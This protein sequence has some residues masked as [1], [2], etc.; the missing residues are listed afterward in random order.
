MLK[1]NCDNCAL[2]SANG[3]ICPF[4]RADMSGKDGCP[5]HASVEDFCEACGNLIVGPAFIIPKDGEAKRVCGHCATVRDCRI[6]SQHECRFEADHTCPEPLL[7]MVRRQEGNMI[8]Q[9]QIMNPKRIAATCALGCP[10]YNKL[11]D[12]QIG[13]CMRQLGEGDNCPNFN[14]KWRN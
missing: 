13:V 4:F 8:V 10:C 11:P 14:L 3:G 6:C 5:R 12:E 7:V 2:P 9:Q 1:R